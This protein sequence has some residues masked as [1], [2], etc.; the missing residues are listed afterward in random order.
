M[1]DPLIGLSVSIRSAMDQSSRMVVGEVDRVRVVIGR[2]G[3]KWAVRLK[4]GRHP[5]P[6]PFPKCSGAD[7][8]H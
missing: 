6:S 7:F 2:R 5:I 8:Q 1:D 4:G 3:V